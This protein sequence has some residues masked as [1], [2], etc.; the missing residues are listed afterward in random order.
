[1]EIVNGS[2]DPGPWHIPSGKLTWQW[3]I[4]LLKMNSL[5]KMGIFHCYV[6]LPE[7]NAHICFSATF[8]SNFAP[9]VWCDRMGVQLLAKPDCIGGHLPSP[10][11]FP[12]IS[13]LTFG[14]LELRVDQNTSM[15]I[16]VC[17]F[18]C[19][20]K[21]ITPL[22]TK[23]TLEHHPFAIGN[24]S[25]NGIVIH[26]PT[27]IVTLN[28]MKSSE[29]GSPQSMVGFGWWKSSRQNSASTRVRDECLKSIRSK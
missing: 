27:A 1:M 7:G 3:K 19:F 4:T 23:M 5:L 11:K 25:S 22:K 2:L 15:I 21:V 29:D 26:V 13:G 16:Y 6:S 8:P 18:L 28:T 24:A 20:E 14:N 10:P 9:A 12:S 17:I